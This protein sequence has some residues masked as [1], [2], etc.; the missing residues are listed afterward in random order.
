MNDLA[1]NWITRE[2]TAIHAD[3]NARFLWCTDENALNTLPT[4]LH[5]EQLLVLTNRWDVAEQAKARGFTTEFNDFDCS[6]IADN[7]L[8]KIFYRVSKEKP[9]VHHLF[10][11]AWRCLKP[12][13]KLLLAGY[14]NEGT[15]TYIEKI[16]K[17]FGS[18]K[19]IVKNGPVY[20]SELTKYTEYNA[21]ELLDDSDYRQP[22]LIASDSGLQLH[23]KPGLFGWNKVD[24]G[25]ALLIEQL[26]QL[27][28]Q[29]NPLNTC[30]DLG[31]GYGYL[32]I[33]AASLD[34]CSSINHWIM[35]DNNAAAL[36][37]ARQNLQFNQLNG[38]I[39]AADAGKGINAKADLLLCNP[40]FHQGFGIDG[41]LTDKFLLNAKH[42]LAPQGIALFVVNQFIPLERKAAPLFKEINTLADNG[43][44]KVI[45]LAN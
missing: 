38:D 3:K 27:S 20:S 41:D 16:A 18:G 25:S 45:S 28:P 39:I 42:L 14:K 32:A 4:A 26:K 40:P 22:R 30:V 44:F 8:D 29:P 33:A 36:Q 23:S 12:G 43:S 9:V 5:E 11:Q 2:L 31:C 19:N 35:T 6:E 34:I 17:L 21:A 10:N 37:L 13:G 7:S 1:L 15:K 24:A